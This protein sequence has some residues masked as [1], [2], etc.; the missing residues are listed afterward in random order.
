MRRLILR[1][2]QSPG[3]IVMLTAAVRDLHR[4]HP[5]RFVTDVRTS[6][7]PLWDYNPHRTRLD[8]H[9]PAVEVREM[10]DPL[11]HHSNQRPY[12]FL[13]GFPQYL[14][15]ILGVP[16]PLTE[17]RGEI[18]LSAGEK[19]QRPPGAKLGLPEHFWIVVAGGKF[20]FNAKWWKPASYQAVVDHFFATRSRSSSAAK[21]ATGILA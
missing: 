8:E 18:P 15:Q 1:T 2:F 9:E 17:F 14:E 20:D 21:Q 7:D 6:C 3:D 12:H 16:V 5:G 10:H 19:Q 4:A 11:I 13:H